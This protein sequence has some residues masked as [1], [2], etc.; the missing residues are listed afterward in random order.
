MAEL[1]LHGVQVVGYNIKDGELQLTL[2]IAW[3]FP[4]LIKAL[5]KIALLGIRLGIL[6]QEEAE[7]WIMNFI[8][9]GGY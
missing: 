4:V 9:R 1:I 7:R 8:S 6:K 5:C 3:W 2:R